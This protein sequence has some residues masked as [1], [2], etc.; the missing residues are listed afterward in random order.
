MRVWLT[1]L[2]LLALAILAPS[3]ATAADKE[4]K[5]KKEPRT[6]LERHLEAARALRPSGSVEG[7]PSPGSAFTGAGRYADL[8]RDFRASL[9]GDILTIVVSDRASAVSRGTTTSK[10]ESTAQGGIH[11]L[12][13]A[14]SASSPLTQLGGMS[15]SQD[16]QGQGE[17]SRSSTLTTTL[18]ARVVEVLP[19]GDLLVEGAKEVLINS[20]RQLVEIRG[21]AR[22]NDI[23]PS[24]QLRSDRLAQLE[25]R[26]NGRGVV[27]D[28]IRRPN[29][30]YRLFMSLLPF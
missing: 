10:R 25:V 11:A 22:W 12:G 3:S 17:T 27:G 21:I 26:V 15:G 16:L 18:S 1:F 13:G 20:E 23:S 5:K 8:A 14:L 4:N 19:N 6:S 30:L 7:S 9:A 24:N 28:V 2:L 29:F